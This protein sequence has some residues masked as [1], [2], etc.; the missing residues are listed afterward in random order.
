MNN[1]NA[2]QNMKNMKSQGKTGF[3]AF[4]DSFYGSSTLGDRGQIVIPA[5]AR[6]DFGFQAG[7]KLLILRHPVHQAIM[8]CK[9]ESFRELVDEFSAEVAK[10]E[11]KHRAEQET[12]S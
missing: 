2:A 10:L 7:D 4:S 6:A 1:T 5:E 9:I 8:I 3:P 11:A 12:E